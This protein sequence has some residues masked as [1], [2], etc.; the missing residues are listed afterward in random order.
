MD[1]RDRWQ[2]LT[3]FSRVVLEAEWRV[4]SYC[5]M[6]NHYHLMLEVPHGN[7]A[8][9][10]H[11]LNST[12]ASRFNRRHGWVGSH[13]F[14]KRYF[15]K[16]VE[17]HRYLMIAFG[18]VAMNPVKAKLCRRPELW[19]WSS[20]PALLGLRA[21]AAVLD[22]SRALELIHRDPRTARTLLRE[23]IYNP[24]RERLLKEP[25]PQNLLDLREY[26]D[27]TLAELAAHFG[28]SLA[29]VRRRAEQGEKK[30]PGTFFSPTDAV[31]KPP[32]STT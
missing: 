15:S 4:L 14:Q 17:D 11:R 20:T 5:F 7:L 1:D 9:G 27:M 22:R 12:F 28:L 26:H 3:L 30:V 19:S 32:P 29:T 6:G 25:T 18:Y 10:M 23:A 16:V 31:D 24:E 13:L 8:W 2:F 21:P